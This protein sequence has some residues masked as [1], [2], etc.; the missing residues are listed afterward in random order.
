MAEL[1]PVVLHGSLVIESNDRSDIAPITIEQPFVGQDLL[2]AFPLPQ[3]V[4]L[5]RHSR[6]S[7]S[8]RKSSHPVHVW[9]FNHLPVRIPLPPWFWALPIGSALAV[10]FVF[11]R[12][13]LYARAR[14]VGR[15]AKRAGRVATAILLGI[16]RILKAVVFL[17]STLGSLRSRLQR[18]GVAVTFFRL[19]PETQC[20]HLARQIGASWTPLTTEA[21]PLFEL[22]LGPEVP[23]DVDRCVLAL[24]AAD[25]KA[26]ALAELAAVDEGENG[27]TIVLSELPRAEVAEHVRPPRRLVVLNKATMNRVLRAPRPALAFA[28]AISEQVDR[29]AVSLYR[30][31]MAGRRQPFYGRKSELRRVT[32]DPARNHLLIGPQGIGKTIL[33][34]EIHRR[35]CAQP[36]I[37]CHYLSLADGDL[38][39]ALADALGMPGE[40]LLDI[41]LERLADVPDGKRVVVLCDDADVWATRDA[42]HGGAQLQTLALLSQEHACSF[43]LAGFLGLLYAARPVRGRKPFGHI[44]RLESLDAEACADLVTVPM[45]ALNVHPAKADLV[46]EIARQT[47][48]MPSLL[49]ALCDQM[50]AGLPAEEHMLERADFEHAC[51]SEAVARVVTAWR[52]RFGL[53]EPRFATLDQAVMLSAVFKTR[54]SLEELQAGLAGLGVEASATEIQHSADRLVAACVFEHWLGHFHFRVPMFQTVMQEAT[55]ARMIAQLSPEQPAEEQ[56][57]SA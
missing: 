10:G 8:V 54:F 56:A 52:P 3:G 1:R 25:A 9:T 57:E 39:S 24:P 40:P 18:R 30:S 48:G 26:P 22:R 28:Q 13:R 41:L 43:V 44:V 32:A 16:A 7:L 11:W 12:A 19:Q 29:L 37:E 35:L 5:D 46:E 33:L 6:V 27:V 50:L 31:A 23:L 49:V 51:R 20:S 34:D 47:G 21:Q 36:G 2:L 17:R 38:T 45:A 53:P 14:P 55:L 42:A 15:A 4:R